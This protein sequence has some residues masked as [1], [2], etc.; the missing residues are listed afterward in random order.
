M[1]LVR[2]YDR[3]ELVCSTLSQLGMICW[4]EGRYEEGLRATEEGLAIARALKSPALIF[5]NQI[6]LANLLHDM[7]RLERAIAEEQELCDMLTGDLE[8]AR[9]GAPA[10]PR[11]TALSFMGWFLM[12]TGEYAR[13]L[14]FSERGLEIAVRE[15]DPY[16]E[17]LARSALGQSLLMLSRNAEAVDCLATARDLSERNGYDAIKADLAGRIAIA[18]ARTARAREAVVIVED[19]LRQRLH[20]RTGQLQV[21]HLYS[22]YA[23]ALVRDGDIDR[24]FERL[25]E[26]LAIARRINNPCL[27]VDGLGL[28]AR[29]L[30][31]VAPGDSR[32]EADLAEQGKICRRY[33]IAAWPG[34][35]SETARGVARGPDSVA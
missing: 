22:G 1:E 33:G 26:A 6:M 3:P 20:L 28:R 9:L 19:C 2:G 35:D 29:L 7:G 17:V 24:G 34:L 21:Y 8:N 27:T 10:I 32:I 4:F 5:S 15:Q 16:S 31:D 23:E 11:T 30:A 13:G 18:L 12:D 14:E 25:S